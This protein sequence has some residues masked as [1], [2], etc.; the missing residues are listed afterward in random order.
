MSCG[1]PE[2]IEME[3]EEGQYWISGAKKKRVLPKKKPSK[4][5]NKKA[6]TK[7]SSSAKNSPKREIKS[8]KGCS[9]QSTK[10][11]AERPSPPYPA[12]ECCHS[13]MIGNDGNTY[14]STQNKH[15]VCSWKK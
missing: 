11:Y 12:N 10:K 7:K 1:L 4:T 15:G 9:R 6:S 5:K 13:V 8:A 14:R 3:S 2:D